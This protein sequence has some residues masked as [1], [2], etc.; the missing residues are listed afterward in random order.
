MEAA[1]QAGVRRTH[2]R[3]ELFRAIAASEEHPDAESL[4]RAVRRRLPTVSLDTVYRTLWLLHGLGLV[5]T[6]WP[7]PGGMRFDPNLDRHHHFTCVRCGRVRDFESSELDGLRIPSRVRELG[8][9]LEARVEVRGVCARCQ[10]ARPS[11]PSRHAIQPPARR[12]QP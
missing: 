11:R 10:A 5:A 4:F 12:N 2:Q 7:K 9:V 1:H 8:G 3:L 6:L